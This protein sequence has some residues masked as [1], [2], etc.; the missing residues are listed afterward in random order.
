MQCSKMAYKMNKISLDTG[1][2]KGLYNEKIG[3]FKC[4]N[5]PGIIDKL[6]LYNGQK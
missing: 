1:E 4:Q 5:M 3:M 2:N 6:G